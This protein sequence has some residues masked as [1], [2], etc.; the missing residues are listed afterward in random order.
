[1]I[2][3][4]ISTPCCAPQ[5]YKIFTCKVFKRKEK[6]NTTIPIETLP[7]VII[8]LLPLNTDLSFYT[9]IL[10]L[11]PGLSNHLSAL[12]DSSELGF[13]NRGKETSKI[14]LSKRHY[15]YIDQPNILVHRLWSLSTIPL[16]I[17]GGGY[18]WRNGSFS[19][20]ST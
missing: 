14:Y 13:V 18:S 17:S 6:N 5:I 7:M 15:F 12:Q 16:K 8:K 19:I 2:Y 9:L 4:Y 3:T 20:W 11:G 1:M 10:M